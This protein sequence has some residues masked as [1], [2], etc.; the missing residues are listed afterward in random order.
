MKIVGRERERERVKRSW[1][2]EVLRRNE[3]KG[4]AKPS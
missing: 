4:E 1:L 2:E 3:R